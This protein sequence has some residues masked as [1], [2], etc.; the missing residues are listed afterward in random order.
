MPNQLTIANFHEQ[1]KQVMDE[2]AIKKYTICVLELNCF[3][4]I[5]NVICLIYVVQAWLKYYPNSFGVSKQ[6]C[7][8]IIK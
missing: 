8:Y 7:N 3:L 6:S 1:Q 2:A 5:N 4:M